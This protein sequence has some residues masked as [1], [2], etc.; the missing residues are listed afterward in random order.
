MKAIV[1]I[2]LICISFYAHADE[3]NAC[4]DRLENDA[5]FAPLVEKMALSDPTAAT[6]SQLANKEK[7]SAEEKP[8]IEKYATDRA[9][10]D[11]MQVRQM[12]NNIHPGIAP[13]FHKNAQNARN[14]LIQLFNGDVSY[15]E[16]LQARK[17]SIEDLRQKISMYDEEVMRHNQMAE[18]NNESLRR[19]QWADFLGNIGN[20]IG[21]NNQTNCWRNSFGDVTCR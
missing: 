5:S 10:C 3:V 2:F 20:A 16:Y 7:A 19:M 12:P 9:V 8:L 21:G 15:G 6:F 13:A 11:E 17:A 18:R 1:S 4:F 14:S